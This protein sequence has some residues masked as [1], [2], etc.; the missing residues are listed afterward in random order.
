MKEKE[1]IP[2][3]VRAENGKTTCICKQGNKK[4]DS[5]DCERD[6]VERDAYRD[7][8]KLF[9]QDRYGKC[10]EIESHG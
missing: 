9:R 2:V 7:V 5:V 4:C 6:M 8:K 1:L 10:R 3:F